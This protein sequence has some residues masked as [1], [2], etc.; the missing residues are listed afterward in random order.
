KPSQ[1]NHRGRS[2]TRSDQG[3]GLVLAHING[4]CSLTRPET[5]QIWRLRTTA[6]PSED[7]WTFITK[8]ADRQGETAT[9]L[10]A[11]ERLAA[12]QLDRDP[13]A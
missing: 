13:L 6:K 9:T 3:T 1:P 10:Y 4:I 12:R 7:P 5:P 2:R 8:I 11:R